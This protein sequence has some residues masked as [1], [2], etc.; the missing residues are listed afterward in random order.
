LEFSTK[1]V[2]LMTTLDEVKKYKEL[3]RSMGDFI[4]IILAAV[5]AI[6]SVYIGFNFYQGFGGQIPQNIILSGVEALISLLIFAA[7]LI[8]GIF[9]VDRRVRRVKVGE[10]K[11]MEKEARSAS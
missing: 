5:V 3:A 9:W 11:A 2:E 7:A 10:W 1:V 8:A 6:L 4:I